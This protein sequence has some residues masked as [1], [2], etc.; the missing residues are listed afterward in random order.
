MHRVGLLRRKLLAAALVLAAVSGSGEAALQVAVAANF[1]S[2]FVQLAEGYSGEIAATYGSSGLL[3]AQI[4]QGRS[5]DAFLSADRMRPQA[6]L[7]ANLAFAPTAYASGR[8][9][10]LVRDSAPGANW[11]AGPR[12]RVAI[13]NPDTAPYGRAAE[14]TLARLG[15][16]V[17]RITALNVAQAFHFWASGAVD[18]AF[19]AMAQVLAEDTPPERYWIVPEGLHAPI[20]QVAVAIRGGNEAAAMAFLQYLT[21]DGAQALVR[22]AG[23]R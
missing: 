20:E 18:G 19:A 7:D 6:L 13:A 14:E 22:T 9:V 21:S 8:I 17:K 23:Y 5:F 15:A 3:Y 4:V 11:L 16:D 12:K 1:Q 10:L 2:A